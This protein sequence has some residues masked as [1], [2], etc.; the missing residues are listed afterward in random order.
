[1]GACAAC[2]APS[3][4]Y[5][6]DEVARMLGC[7][8]SHVRDL[9]NRGEL[10]ARRISPRLI[11][12]PAGRFHD[13]LEGP[14]PAEGADSDLSL[15]V[16]SAPPEVA[17]VPHLAAVRTRRSRRSSVSKKRETA[18]GAHRGPSDHTPDKE[19]Q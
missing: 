12:I 19:A 6:I 3:S 8:T 9:I 16:G 10:P 11:L 14:A 5:R 15:R 1:M 13:W 2:G 7:S 18:P 4:P 17:G